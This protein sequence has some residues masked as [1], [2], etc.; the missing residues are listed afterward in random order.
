MIGTEKAKREKVLDRIQALRNKT[1]EQGC[2]EEEAIAASQLIGKL[3]DE[4]NLTMTDVEL[5]SIDCIEDVIATPNKRNNHPIVFCLVDLADFC[6][7]RVWTC[8]KC[9]LDEKLGYHT[10]K[11]TYVFF[12]LPQDVATANYLYHVIFGAM[13]RE[14]KEFKKTDYYLNL[15][16]K[17]D[18]KIAS[19]SFLR[20]MANRLS[21][22][23]VLM[24]DERNKEI[25]KT[26]GRNLVVVKGSHLE[27][28]LQQAG[29]HIGKAKRQYHR[30]NYDGTASA[31]GYQAGGRVG[32]N[33]G[34]GSG[35]SQRLLG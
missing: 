24:K 29:Y 1:V 23:L 27:T 30:I 25:I 9:M 18:K 16:F 14:V 32:L 19:N 28:A 21:T 15:E 34:V 4:Y 5:G 3:M 2:T 12:G 26:T 7:V 13:D 8:R 33:K 6:D 35:R 10:P 31:A 17:G 11:K 20:G 22:R